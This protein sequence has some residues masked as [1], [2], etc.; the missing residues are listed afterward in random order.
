MRAMTKT[1]T[2]RTTPHHTKLCI[3]YNIREIYLIRLELFEWWWDFSTCNWRDGFL[4]N[5]RV[6][7]FFT[8]YFAVV[9]LD[10]FADFVRIDVY[11]C[12]HR[13][14][15]N[16]KC[17]LD[18]T[19]ASSHWPFEFVQ[20]PFIYYNVLSKATQRLNTIKFRIEYIE[21][22]KTKPNYKFTF[23]YVMHVSWSTFSVAS[24]MLFFTSVAFLHS[25]YHHQ[26]RNHTL[27]NV[28]KLISY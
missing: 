22:E 7:L 15:I 17:Y 18:S 11:M 10:I 1:A 25:V 23:N 3:I 16:T 26:S 20:I 24:T 12:L 4:W 5:V 28:Y 8:K 13:K 19:L 14:R 2:T 21:R 9:L 27:N 6:L